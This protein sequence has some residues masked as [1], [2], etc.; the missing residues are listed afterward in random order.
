MRIH[1][2]ISV[3]RRLT[4]KECTNFPIKITV[5][6]TLD[7]EFQT[8]KNS[9]RVLTWP[10]NV[11]FGHHFKSLPVG[12]PERGALTIETRVHCVRCALSKRGLLNNCYCSPILVSIAYAWIIA[13]FWIR[14]S[15]RTAP[16]SSRWRT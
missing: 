14:S 16:F 15:A 8:F 3:P 5:I 10:N 2:I 11:K 7:S 9:R 12:K 6:N 13:D 1:S 4:Q